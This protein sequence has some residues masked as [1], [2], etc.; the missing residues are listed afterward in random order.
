MRTCCGLRVG[1]PNGP[2]IKTPTEA[3]GP[4]WSGPWPGWS[5]AG[6]A[7][8]ATAASADDQWLH[9]RSAGLNLRRLLNL[10][11]QLQQGSWVLA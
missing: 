9:H 8:C 4:W 1:K 6:T 11:L 10:G 2:T 7:D 3:S 5:A